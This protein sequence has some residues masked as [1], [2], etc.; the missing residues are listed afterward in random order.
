MNDR[1]GDRLAVLL[2]GFG[3]FPGAPTNPTARLVTRLA[4]RRRPRL[5]DIARQAHVLPVS[6]D[7]V[8][9]EVPRLIARHRPRLVLLFGL[10]ART[11]TIRIEAQARN[12]VSALSPDA[13]GRHAVHPAIEAH[14]PPTRRCG[15]PLPR[16]VQ[17]V[18]ALGLPARL[19]RDA[20]RYICNLAYWQALAHPG[21]ALVQF[22]HVPGTRSQGRS[23]RRRLSDDDLLEAAEHLLLV[24]CAH[25]RTRR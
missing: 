20:G 25:A 15:S 23:G 3:R 5:A 10:A 17:A 12:A 13:R 24:L 22:V 1:S 11:P 4:R 19:S 8:R 18:R 21:P 14:G 6:Y 9:R 2:I 7:E 16:L